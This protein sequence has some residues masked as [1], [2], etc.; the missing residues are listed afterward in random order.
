MKTKTDQS[1]GR[2]D[3]GTSHDRWKD[4]TDCTAF[5]KSQDSPC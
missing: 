4:L 3:L 5:C 2:S 1:G